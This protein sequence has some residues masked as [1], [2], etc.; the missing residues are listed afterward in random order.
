MK[1]FFGRIMVA[2]T[3]DVVTLAHI[4]GKRNL[5]FP[6]NISGKTGFPATSGTDGLTARL[7]FLE[8]ESVFNHNSVFMIPAI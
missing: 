2:T 6:V 5:P 1:I 7:V 3:V 4:V 8:V